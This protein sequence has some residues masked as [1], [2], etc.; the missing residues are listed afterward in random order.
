MMFQHASI[1]LV[2]L[3]SSVFTQRIEVNIGSAQEKSC[4]RQTNKFW[5]ALPCTAEQ[6]ISGEECV[7]G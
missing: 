1:H 4:G 3:P 2:L 5:K 6:L 7:L